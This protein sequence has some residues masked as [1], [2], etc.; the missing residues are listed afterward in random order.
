MTDRLTR[1]QR[2]LARIPEPPRNVPAWWDAMPPTILGL[3]ADA[4]ALLDQGERL[5]DP[6]PIPEPPPRDWRTVP[7]PMRMARLPR[8]YRGYPIFYTVQPDQ[9]PQDGDRIDFRVLNQAHHV[10]C[11]LER[12]CAICNTRLGSQLFFVGGPMCVQNRVFGD[13]PVHEECARYAMRVCPY[14]SIA[15]KAYRMSETNLS[16]YEGGEDRFDPNVLLNK[17]QR[18]VVYICHEYHLKPAPGGKHLF[19][20][21]PGGVCEWYDTSGNYLCRTRPT[22]FAQ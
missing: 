8:D 19:M 9:P 18:V 6:D 14:L 20:V 1:A 17:P 22:R 4:P 5:P 13:G 21:P 16:G 2:V 11:A 7:L 10:T 3:G 15:S 12:R